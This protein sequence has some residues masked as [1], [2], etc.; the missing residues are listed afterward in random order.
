MLGFDVAAPSE[1][2]IQHDEVV[3]DNGIEFIILPICSDLRF[4]GHIPLR[5]SSRGR[6]TRRADDQILRLVVEERQDP[7]N[8]QSSIRQSTA[9]DLLDLWCWR[10][11]HPASLRQPAHTPTGAPTS[12][13]YYCLH[14]ATI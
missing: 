8:R 6:Q 11:D 13:E 3:G 1:V 9:K 5:V 12:I 7:R 14:L 2:G 4:V 10:Q